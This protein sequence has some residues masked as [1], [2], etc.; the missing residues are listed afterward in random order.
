MVLLN[1]HFMEK[2]ELQGDQVDPS[3]KLCVLSLSLNLFRIN[4][5]IG[6]GW[7]CVH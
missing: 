3:L 1:T 4:L 2:N 5:S 6:A 7:L